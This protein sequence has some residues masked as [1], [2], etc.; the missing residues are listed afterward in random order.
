MRVTTRTN[1]SPVGRIFGSII[2]VIMGIALVMVSSYMTKQGAAV[3]YSAIELPSIREMIP[4]IVC[5]RQGLC[6]VSDHTA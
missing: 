6:V 3:N 4:F 5:L 2:M 1:Q